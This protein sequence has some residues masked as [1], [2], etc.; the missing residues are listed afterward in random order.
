MSAF[1]A[2]A[3]RHHP[4]RRVYYWLDLYDYMNPNRPDHNKLMS[5]VVIV[6]FL[7]GHFSGHDFE[8]SEEIV[9]GALSLGPRIFAQMLKGKEALAEQKAR[10][11]GNVNAVKEG[12]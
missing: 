10:L 9:L 1:D 7:V 3:F 5:T 2:P 11:S 12:D 8:V 6:A 4:L